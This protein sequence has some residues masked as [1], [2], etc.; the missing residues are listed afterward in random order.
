MTS[1]SVGTGYFLLYRLR[2]EPSFSH[3]LSAKHPVLRV[4]IS[5]D[6]P[7]GFHYR[8][9]VSITPALLWVLIA[10]PVIISSHLAK[11]PLGAYVCHIIN[12]SQQSFATTSCIAFTKFIDWR[13]LNI[14]QS[15]RLRVSLTCIFFVICFDNS[16]SSRESAQARPYVSYPGC[17]C[18]L[19]PTPTGASTR[20]HPTLLGG[21]PPCGC[22]FS[23]NHYTF[24]YQI[25]FNN[26]RA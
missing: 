16:R 12:G 10:A 13:R 3:H 4:P 8:P 9:G 6:L 11:L 21:S 1:S 18:R 25:L 14:E 19:T 26:A 5:V 23:C 24:F 22:L 7:S 17:V 20:S 2:A 15:Y